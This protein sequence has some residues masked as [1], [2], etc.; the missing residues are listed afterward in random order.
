MNNEEHAV[1]LSA[2]NNLN[3]NFVEVI[4]TVCGYRIELG[5]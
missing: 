1:L 4:D 5:Q 2:M 3:G